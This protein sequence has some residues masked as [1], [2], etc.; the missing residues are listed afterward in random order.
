MS[1]V[2]TAPRGRAEGSRL[3]P[4]SGST[5]VFVKPP[6]VME[7]PRRRLIVRDEHPVGLILVGQDTTL[8]RG[9]VDLLRSATRQPPRP[10]TRMTYML[11]AC[12]APLPYA[13]PVAVVAGP[14]VVVARASLSVASPVALPPAGRREC[15][16]DPRPPR[17]P[18][19]PGACPGPPR[20]IHA[21][22]SAG[23]PGPAPGRSAPRHASPGG[24]GARAPHQEEATGAGAGR[25][26]APSLVSSA[27]LNVKRREA[28]RPTRRVRG[29]T[30]EVRRGSSGLG[31]PR[32]APGDP[33]PPPSA[34]PPGAG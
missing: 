16:A 13:G 5:P 20:G 29:G 28:R 33:P 1:P 4:G 31:P 26:A 34:G 23:P 9:R 8:T 18:R 21:P 24:A 27:I 32:A 15:R 2:E 7:R 6:R 11:L 12:Q 17:R 22:T 19:P 3:P 14:F 25:I 10:T 30:L